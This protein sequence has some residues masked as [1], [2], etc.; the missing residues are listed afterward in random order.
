MSNKEILKLLV[1]LGEMLGSVMG[2]ISLGPDILLSDDALGD[3]NGMNSKLDIALISYGKTQSL[4]HVLRE[5][6]HEIILHEVVHFTIFNVQH[7][8]HA[9]R[10]FFW[11]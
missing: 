3:A 11:A 6:F 7:S 1:T 10:H 9:K 8:C 4:F 5:S 2:I